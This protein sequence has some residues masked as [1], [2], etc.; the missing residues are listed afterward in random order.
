[1][2]KKKPKPASRKK[3]TPR[4]VSLTAVHPEGMIF[5][6]TLSEIPGDVGVNL[7]V[8][9]HPR[10]D[11]EFAKSQLALWRMWANGFC[12]GAVLPEPEGWEWIHE[13]GAPPSAAVH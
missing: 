2:A 12:A 10:V 1:M 8:E 9:A 3:P 7:T 6:I 4:A 11:P 5:T 13:E